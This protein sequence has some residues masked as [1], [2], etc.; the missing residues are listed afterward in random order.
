MAYRLILPGLIAINIGVDE[1]DFLAELRTPGTE[2]RTAFYRG[3]LRQMV[4]LRESLIKS[5]ANGSNPA[6]QELIKFIKSQQQYLFQKRI[7]NAG[8][9]PMAI[10]VRIMQSRMVNHIRLLVPNA[11]E[12]RET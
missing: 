2:V 10:Q 9:R 8:A 1:T 6:Q 12:A 4:E 11:P 5:A 7:L 3:H